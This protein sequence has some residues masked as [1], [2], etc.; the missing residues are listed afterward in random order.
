MKPMMILGSMA[1]FLIGA[2]FSFA[3]NCPWPTVL[4]RACVG[5]LLA[6]LLARW[7][8][9]VWLDGLQNAIEN[10]RQPRPTVNSETKVKP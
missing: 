3:G 8:N 10:R 2:G 7:W 4:W 5:A 1:G 9:R 6:G